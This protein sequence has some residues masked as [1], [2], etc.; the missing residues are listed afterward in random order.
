[1]TPQ[2]RTDPTSLLGKAA[3]VHETRAFDLHSL[4]KVRTN[5]QEASTACRSCLTNQ[6]RLYLLRLSDQGTSSGHFADCCYLFVSK[7]LLLTS[8]VTITWKQKAV[9]NDSKARAPSV[10]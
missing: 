3:A 7:Q 4:S 1:M 2:L 9:T 6:R 10:C 5:I 8:G